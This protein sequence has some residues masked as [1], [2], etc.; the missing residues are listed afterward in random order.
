MMKL[1][2]ITDPYHFPT[3][4]QFFLVL[5]D[6]QAHAIDQLRKVGCNLSQQ[7]RVVEQEQ[8]TFWAVDDSI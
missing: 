3:E 4:D 8:P 6:N 1:F 5:A 7:A 2:K